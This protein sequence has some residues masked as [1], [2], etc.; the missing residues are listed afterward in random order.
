LKKSIDKGFYNAETEMRK[1]KINLLPLLH[2]VHLEAAKFKQ[3]H[4]ET[5]ATFQ[6]TR[7]E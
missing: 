3:R 1:I 6:E 5:I 4:S 7:H 2:E